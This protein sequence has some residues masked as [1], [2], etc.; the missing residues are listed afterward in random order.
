MK[1]RLS[2]RVGAVRRHPALSAESP[3]EEAGAELFGLVF[4]KKVV[5]ADFPHPFTRR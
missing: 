2:Y 1:G 3:M 4:R 5:G